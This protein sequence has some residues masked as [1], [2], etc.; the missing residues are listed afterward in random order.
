MATPNSPWEQPDPRG[1]PAV[2]GILRVVVA[3][4]CWGA[5]AERLQGRGSSEL[6]RLLFHGLN[7]SDPA[8]VQLDRFV[9]AALL[10]VGLLSL[11]RPVWIAQFAAAGWFV[12]QGFAVATA[13][14]GN[15]NSFRLAEQLIRIAPPI[16]LALVDWYPPK[17]RFT[18]GRF[19]ISLGMLKYA[20]VISLSAQGL[21]TLLSIPDRARLLEMTEKVASTFK[22]GSWSP[23]QA[24]MAVGALGGIDIGVALA[25]AASRS[26]AVALVTAAWCLARISLWTFAFGPNGYADTLLR[27]ALVGAPLTMAA[28]SIFA[29]KEQPPEILPVAAPKKAA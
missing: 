6:A 17:L 7:G 12:A 4:Q 13:A 27:V 2:Q 9:A 1:L 29:V 19:L 26:R 22:W 10:V 3:V 23:D 20:A 24:G 25:F 11:V 21:R 28:F 5:A 15:W 16:A 8:I 18:L 14:D